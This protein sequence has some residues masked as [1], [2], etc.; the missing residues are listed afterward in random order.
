MSKHACKQKKKIKTCCRG[1]PSKMNPHKKG[2]GFHKF[3][4]SQIGGI[5]NVLDEKFLNWPYLIY[6]II[7]KPKIVFSIFHFLLL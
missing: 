7:R 6:E 2:D 1:P 5:Q 4:Y 3:L